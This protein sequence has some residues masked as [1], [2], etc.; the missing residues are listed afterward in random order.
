[1][2]IDAS[3]TIQQIKLRAGEPTLIAGFDRLE[4]EGEAKRL[5]PG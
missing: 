2:V 5:A 1:M 4:Q 3:G